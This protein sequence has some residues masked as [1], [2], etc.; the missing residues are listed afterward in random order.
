M[1][2]KAYPVRKSGY[3]FYFQ[4][5]DNQIACFGS[6]V[7][8]KEEVY[9][10]DELVSVKRNLG[11][12]GV[13]QF[14]IEDS[15]YSI[16]YELTNILSGKVK[17]SFLKGTKTLSLQSQSIFSDNPKTAGGIILWCFFVGFVFGALGYTVSQFFLGWV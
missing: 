7:S 14:T 15:A 3:K 8:G 17:C 11:F 4:E 6:F 5:G 1:D 2:N 16:V 13:H 12:K 9:V 10:N